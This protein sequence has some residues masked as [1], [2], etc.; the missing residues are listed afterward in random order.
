MKP[1]TNK[2]KLSTNETVLTSSF[3]QL[4]VLQTQLLSK[5]APTTLEE[6]KRQ[7]QFLKKGCNK[8]G[9]RKRP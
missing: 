7:V 8:Q 2:K 5:Q 3:C 4:A 1:L 6:A 9:G